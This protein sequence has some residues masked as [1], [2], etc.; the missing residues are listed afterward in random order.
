MKTK[1]YMFYDQTAEQVVGVIMQH[2]APAAAIRDFH[3]VLGNPETMPG[4]YPEHYDLI[5]LGELET[6]NG[7]ITPTNKTIATGY[8][9][10]E[11]RDREQAPALVK[12]A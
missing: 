11:A 12:Q 1:L 4:R 2:K 9:W 8:S 6:D 5:E 7:D 10:K 3:S